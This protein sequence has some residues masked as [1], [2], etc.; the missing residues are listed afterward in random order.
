MFRRKQ[1][2]DKL[3]AKNIKKLKALKDMGFHIPIETPKSS[4]PPILRPLIWVK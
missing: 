1:S 4:E 2:K 3:S